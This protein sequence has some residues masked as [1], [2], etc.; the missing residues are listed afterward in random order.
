MLQLFPC[1]HANM[2]QWHQKRCLTQAA[3]STTEID[4]EVREPEDARGAIS[5]GLSLYEEG[6]YAE[7]LEVFEKGLDLP[8]TGMKRFRYLAPNAMSRSLYISCH[9]YYTL[10]PEDRT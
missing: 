6:K 9:S 5:V 8:G 2:H 10:L 1:R 7:A 4:S 3:S